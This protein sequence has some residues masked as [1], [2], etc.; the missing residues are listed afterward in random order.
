MAALT[1]AVQRQKVEQG[2]FD[3]V[4]LP[5]GDGGGPDTTAR[6]ARVLLAAG[7]LVDDLSALGVPDTGHVSWVEASGAGGR[8]VTLRRAP[9]EIGPVLAEALWP[10]VTAVLASA[11]VPPLVEDRLG[12]PRAT[13]RV[14]VGSPFPYERCAL[15][16]CAS[17]LPDRRNPNDRRPFV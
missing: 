9:I 4:A 6:R 13:T 12:L 2:A 15:L 7:H 16:Y 8:F 1:G 5:G 3:Q 14:D 11:T 10:N 17:Q